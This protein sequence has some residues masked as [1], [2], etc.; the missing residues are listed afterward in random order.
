MKKDQVKI[1]KI[2]FYAMESH[3]NLTNFSFSSFFRFSPRTRHP[4]SFPQKLR[5][6]FPS[7]IV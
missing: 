7:G 1:N 4:P 2:G 5:K 6:L 3:K